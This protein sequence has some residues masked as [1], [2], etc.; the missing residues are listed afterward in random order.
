[1]A[2]F[3]ASR[4]NGPGAEVGADYNRQWP[5]CNAARLRLTGQ[6]RH[7]TAELAGAAATR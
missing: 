5:N 2:G 7:K 3:L 6:L 4:A 1:M